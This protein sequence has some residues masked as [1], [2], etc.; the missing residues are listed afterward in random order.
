MEI[1]TRI[2]P[3]AVNAD[4]AIAI[5]QEAVEPSVVKNLPLLPVWDGSESTAAHCTPVPVDL[6][7]C[8][9]VPLVAPAVKVPVRVALFRVTAVRVVT[10]VPE[11]MTV[12]PIV[13]ARYPA[14]AAVQVMPFAAVDEAVR[15]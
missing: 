15:M 14:G 1:P 11:L 6:R 8:P 4:G 5:P 3:L 9:F 12:L 7:Y 13:G 2:T 10:V